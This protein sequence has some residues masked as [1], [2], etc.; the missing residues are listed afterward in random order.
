MQHGVLDYLV[1][2]ALESVVT[3][4]P[5]YK[6]TLMHSNNLI[7]HIHKKCSRRECVTGS[8]VLYQGLAIDALVSVVIRIAIKPS[9]FYSSSCEGFERHNKKIL[10]VEN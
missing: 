5:K 10:T 6:S 9:R 1:T 3:F 7:T 8:D 2:T 4:L